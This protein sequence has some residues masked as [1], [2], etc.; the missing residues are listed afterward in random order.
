MLEI[1]ELI[2]QIMQNRIYT[3]AIKF[4]KG[5]TGRGSKL[6]NLILVPVSWTGR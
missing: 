5:Y 6:I 2:N 4:K 1:Q 3:F